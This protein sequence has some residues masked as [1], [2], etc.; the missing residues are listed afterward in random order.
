MHN[1]ITLGKRVLLFITDYLIVGL[2][3]YFIYLGLAG[4]FFKGVVIPQEFIDWSNNSGTFDDLVNLI[5]TNSEVKYFFEIE[6]QFLGIILLATFI[7]SAIYFVL[8]PLVWSGQTIGRRLLRVKVIREN[9]TDPKASSL[10]VR[11][12]IGNCLIN[13]FV[14]FFGLVIFINIILIVGRRRSIADMISG[15]KIIDLK[16][17]LNKNAT[18]E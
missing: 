8:I 17:P 9:N 1:D 15:T 10:I 7:V 2:I 13:L 3:C 4:V 18:L 12:I 14:V 11:E 5:N 6:M 16:E